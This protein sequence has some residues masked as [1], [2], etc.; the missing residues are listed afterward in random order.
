MSPK[1]LPSAL[2]A[3]ALAAACAE[4]GPRPAS[5]APAD[6]VVRGGKIV[7]LDPARPE[8]TALAARGGRIVALGAEADVA[9]LVGPSTR[10]I[11][12][13]GRVAYPGFIE[14]H[15]HF[16]GIGEAAMILKLAPQRTW[17]EIVATVAE[18]AKTTPAG[19]W[20][21]GRGWHQEKWDAPPAGAVEGFPVH[22]ALSAATPEHP[23]VLFHASGHAAFVNA[24]VMALA[25][26]DETTPNPPGGEILRDAAGRATGL[27]REDAEGL[28]MAAFQ[29]AESA[30]PAE[31]IA[32]D[33]R[34]AL[35][36]ADREVLSKGIT[37]FHDAG[38]PYADL[39]LVAAM[40][41][42]GAL[43]VR[44]WV[45]VRDSL[46]NHRARMAEARRVGA[47]DGRLTVAAVKVSLD[48]A[49]G[50]RGAWLLEPYSDLP[51]STGLATTDP[52]VLEEISRLALEHRFQMCVHAIGDRANRETLDVFE[53]VLGSA[54]DG[55]ERRWRVEHAQHLN[56]AEIPRFAALG[57]VPSMQGIHCTSDAPFVVA[58]LGERRAEE[59]AYVWRRLTDA[60]S[61][62]VNGTDAPVEDVDPIA[63]YHATVTRRLA[64]GTRFYPDQVLSRVEALESYTKNAAW[65]A[66]EEQE[67]GTLEVGKY[68]DVTILD[69]DL[70]TV[71][72][73]EIPSARVAYTVVGGAVRYER[74]AAGAAN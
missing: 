56:P 3:L 9:A 39:D 53:R 49:L 65:A 8:A 60:G 52:A 15:G 55:R 70:L 7:T 40:A 4:P 58:R 67:K 28:V 6:L 37:S 16:A 34:R 41:D 45:M 14:G 38:I 74:A 26:I 12:L 72:E 43:G 24:K 21:V 20:I 48:G 66:F 73:E 29:R 27:L 62:I 18:A 19:E 5:L 64:D 13:G 46:D 35:E 1:R 30:R 68:A 71:P 51:T 47:F 36:L 33:A 61:R 57:V 31:R 11:E 23:V 69:R 2:A 50:S 25:G 63:S 59:G 22:E 32:S 42:E 17:D 10:V 54:A 44:L